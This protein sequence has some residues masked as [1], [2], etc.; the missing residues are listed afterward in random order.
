MSLVEIRRGLKGKHRVGERVVL[1]IDDEVV[2]DVTL[3]DGKYLMVEAKEYVLVTQGKTVRLEVGDTW[4]REYLVPDGH[5]MVI[6]YT[7]EDVEP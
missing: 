2:Q 6:H 1:K 5:V 3:Q 4:F 7:Y